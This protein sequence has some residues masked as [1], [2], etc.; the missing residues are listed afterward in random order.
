MGTGDDSGWRGSREVWLQAAYRALVAEGVAAV[1]IQPL[2]EG[3]RLARTSFYWFFKDRAALL[4]ALAD[5][6]A[7]RTTAPLI[8]AT[9][10]YAATETEAML[11]VIGCFLDAGTFDARLEFAIR[12]WALQ[13]RAMHAR[14]LAADA[15]RL[16]ALA[17]MM[18]RWGHAAADADVR[19]HTVYL[20]QIGYI[21]MQTDETL[22]TRLARIPH[23]VE[24]YTGR[25][26]GP[27]EMARFR[28]RFAAPAGESGGAPD[29]EA[30]GGPGAL[31]QT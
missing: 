4:E 23:Y 30:A 16:A 20:V 8:A 17:A 21:A 28:A 24:V 15:A 18:G 12:G 2:A 14:L 5:L 9:R 7:A 10:A 27:A 19:A 22:A 13:D 26:P 11:N 6:W 25:A 3:L 29:A 1:K 31:R